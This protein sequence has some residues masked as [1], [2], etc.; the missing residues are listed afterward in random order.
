MPRPLLAPSLYFKD[1]GLGV[2][3]QLLPAA[4]TTI[5]PADLVLLSNTSG[6]AL[7]LTSAP[8]IPNGKDGQR[9]LLLNVGVNTI[10]F[11]DQGTLPSSNLRLTT[12]TVTIG[13]RQNFTLMYSANI[14]NW[15]QIV[16]LQAV[17]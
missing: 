6:G 17:I 15:V 1:K 2:L 10:T 11:S 16:G 9:C 7:T 5:N 14:G 13:P 12:A 3:R 4:A 8:T